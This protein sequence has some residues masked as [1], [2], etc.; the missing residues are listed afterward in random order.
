MVSAA[1]M[2]VVASAAQN[3]EVTVYNQGFALVKEVRDL[4]LTE[5]IQEVTVEDVAER[6]EANSVAIR[7]LSAPGSITVFEQ[8]YRFDLVSPMA[9]LNKAVGSTVI[10]RRVLPDGSREVIEGTLISSPT[11]VVN[12]GNGEVMT[13][14]GL[15]IRTKEGR[16]LLNPSGEIEVP[17][18]PEGLISKPSLVWTLG[19][20][21]GGNNSV[22]VSYL[23]QGMSWTADYVLALDGDGKV[24]DLKGWVTLVNQAGAS[25]KNAKLKLLAGEVNRIVRPGGFGAGGGRGGMEAMMSK[26]EMQQEAFAEY[27]LYTSPRPVTILNKEMKQVSLLEGQRVPV[28]N[29]L[30]L[31]AT[32]SYG[33]WR[34]QEEGVVGSGPIKPIVLVEFKND[35]ESGLGIPM[36]AGKVKVFQRDSS[37]SLQ[38]LGEAQIDH[39]PRNEKLSLEVGRSFDVVGE[40]KRTAFSWLNRRSSRDGARET[41]EIEVRNRK[42][43][44]AT[45]HV[46]ERAWGEWKITASSDASVK[47]DSNTFQFVVTLK[48]NEVKKVTYTVESYW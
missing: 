15:V 41:F 11:S 14:N 6:I 17:T 27:H 47:L 40:R 38:M 32:R 18:L 37:G 1:L 36:P 48:P 33:Q 12:T 29:K 28:T 4:S 10:L 45:V 2:T 23:T 35:K 31:D 19:A 9:I 13:Y 22:E 43:S 21:S 46:M 16:I 26:A 5:G 42:E 25:F 34:A 44:P 20:K 30:I 39:T 7:S 24:G 8:N 3:P